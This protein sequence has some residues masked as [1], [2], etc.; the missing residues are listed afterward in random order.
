VFGIASDCDTQEIMTKYPVIE[1]LCS[2][3]HGSGI[4]NDW[5]A[6][7]TCGGNIILRNAFHT[8]NEAGMYD[9]VVDFRIVIPKKDIT[10]FKVQCSSN[11]YQW[12]DHDLKVYI[13][14]LIIHSLLDQFEKME[15]VAPRKS[16]FR[17]HERFELLAVK[18]EA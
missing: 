6:E 18:K 8:M 13:D 12:N 4:D 14:D 7:E 16:G 10:A 17:K 5:Y 2:H 15:G 1:D 11:R 9:A 3:V